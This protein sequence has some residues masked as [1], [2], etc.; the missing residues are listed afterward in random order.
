MYKLLIPLL[1]LALVGCE[2]SPA[3]MDLKTPMAKRADP[4]ALAKVL[5]TQPDKTRA[6]YMYRN[7]QKTLEFF[8]VA[9][10]MTVVE[11]LPGGGWYTKILLQYVGEDGHLIG[12]DYAESMWPKFGFFGPDFIA[13]KKTWTTDWVADAEEWGVPNSAPISA[14]VFG[15]MPQD[16]K[17]TA[18]AV[19]FI[20][21]MH[22]LSR[23]ENDG[24]YL[25]TAVRDAYDVLKP[26]GIVGIV[27]HRAPDGASN[28]WASGAKGYL[29]RDFVIAQMRDAGFEYVGSSDVNANPKDN[30]GEQ[31]V[32][33][34]LPPTLITSRDDEELNAKMRTIG[35]SNRMTLK[36]RKP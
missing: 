30:P 19:L 2:H 3:P 7:P 9:P 32:V 4:A 31:D 28:D 13:S 34:R 24:D 27:Q 35:E 23:F 29:K 15:S 6:R 1:L 22:N 12:V 21:A 16:V 36:F 11:A 10:G 5:A 20:R 26:G 33:W 17:G 25:T 8:G 18:D 14:F